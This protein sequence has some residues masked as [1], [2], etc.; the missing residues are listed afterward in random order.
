MSKG[1]N[2]SNSWATLKRRDGNLLLEF[3][4]VGCGLAARSALDAYSMWDPPQID[5]DAMGRDDQQ[6]RRVF[7]D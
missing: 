3:L 4:P 6:S 1:T 5:V 2:Y 7:A